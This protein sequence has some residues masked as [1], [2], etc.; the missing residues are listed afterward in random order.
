MAK[1]KNKKQLKWY[2]QQHQQN[3]ITIKTAANQPKNNPTTIQTTL[4]T[5]QNNKHHPNNRKK[6]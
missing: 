1:I 6:H 2:L 5:I 4:Q 3:N